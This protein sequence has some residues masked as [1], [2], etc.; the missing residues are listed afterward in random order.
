M[1]NKS[2]VIMV[3]AGSAAFVARALSR[4]RRRS[5]LAATTKGIAEVVMPSVLEETP[6]TQQRVAGDEAHAPGH[7]HLARPFLTEREPNRVDDRPFAKHQRG[8]RHPGRR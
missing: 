5:L 2:K 8:F 3:T 7:R 6:S 1:A 4:A